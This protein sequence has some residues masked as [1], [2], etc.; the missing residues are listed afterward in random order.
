MK[1]TLICGYRYINF[2]ANLILYAFIKIRLVSPLR[3][4]SYSW[5]L[6]L[7][8]NTKYVLCPTKQA[9]GLLITG[10]FTPITSVPLL[11]QWTNLTKSVVLVSFF[12]R[13][14]YGQFGPF[15]WLLI[16]VGTGSTA[17]LGQMILGCIRRWAEQATKIKSIA[18][19]YDL[20]LISCLQDFALMSFLSSFNDGTCNM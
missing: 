18:F 2:E 15:S 11:Y 16:D 7:F 6:G 19:V 9:L 5:V 14:A 3:P 20:W 10:L 4:V 12:F 17:M 1:A 13:L 8:S